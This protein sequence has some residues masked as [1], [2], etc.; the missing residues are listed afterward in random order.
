LPGTKF[1]RT[2]VRL[3][4]GSDIRSTCLSVVFPQGRQHRSEVFECT[5][6]TK[7]LTESEV[8]LLLRDL[9]GC[10]VVY[11]SRESDKA[12]WQRYA[13]QV[14]RDDKGKVCL[15]RA[16]RFDLPGTVKATK[17][18][19]EWF[20]PEDFDML[21]MEPSHVYIQR[22]VKAAADS[23]M[24]AA[25]DRLRAELEAQRK[26]QDT[27][28]AKLQKE[29][30]ELKRKR[31][32]RNTPAPATTA[33][34]DAHW[35]EFLQS[36]NEVALATKETAKALSEWVAVLRRERAPEDEGTVPP[37]MY[38]VPS[39]GSFFA[40]G[41]TKS[42]KLHLQQRYEMVAES[43]A[44][45]ENAFAALAS[46]IDASSHAE[47]LPTGDNLTLGRRLLRALRD[48]MA[49]EKGVDVA[50]VHATLAKAGDRDI[51]GKDAPQDW[52][53]QAVAANPIVKPALK[54]N[55]PTG[56]MVCWYCTKPGHSA[57]DCRSR[58]ADGAP[59]PRAPPAH[60][61]EQRGRASVATE[62]H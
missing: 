10:H 15:V 9:D 47:A 36:N 14:R 42:L 5:M 31:E 18:A 48:V 61:N 51:F 22:S 28:L 24:A 49:Q 12:E 40:E 46:W 41:D 35:V 45:K 4:N 59:V 33:Q 60:L 58:V 27:A 43:T 52:Y 25:R 13:G 39:W 2:D 8:R 17:G 37:R 20:S 44:A 26:E 29:M 34:P 19:E 11:K 6:S 23:E 21:S 56:T 57:H 1:E 16:P 38:S 7:P 30:D 54:T 32:S 55:R 3:G 62:S 50:K 53:A